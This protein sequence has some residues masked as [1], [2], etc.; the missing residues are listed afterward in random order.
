MYSKKRNIIFLC[1]I[2]LIAVGGVGLM[3]KERN[4]TG[5]STGG[6]SD[7][8]QE[9]EVSEDEM[10]DEEKALKEERDAFFASMLNTGSEYHR[11]EYSNCRG[12]VEVN[13]EFITD[14][15]VFRD[16]YGMVEYE[17]LEYEELDN[18]SEYVADLDWDGNIDY[19]EKGFVNLEREYIQTGLMNKDGTFNLQTITQ[20]IRYGE[21]DYGEEKVYENQELV[22]VRVKVKYKNLSSKENEI[23]F[24]YMHSVYCFV[25][26][27]DG[28]LYER[29]SV[30]S[31]NVLSTL[32]QPIYKSM[33]DR[34]V[35]DE[36]NGIKMISTTG[37]ILKPHE[38][39][40]GE[41]IYVVLK[42][43]IEDMYFVTNW[44][45][46]NG[47]ITNFKAVGVNF[48]PFSFLKEQVGS[49]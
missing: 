35:V 13:R 11:G 44:A 29:S 12:S 31:R 8:T 10:T 39:Y 41:L 48:I 5:D 40:T 23:T 25:N 46:G 30:Y 36:V 18:L 45:K 22:A 26:M 49:K 34:Y 4:N 7:K 33:A 37:I 3:L 38:E 43:E 9:T 32:W 6:G 2:I 42:D 27:D 28:K 47:D 15:T 17:F 24:S 20:A 1:V 16:V 21:L 19:T 14:K